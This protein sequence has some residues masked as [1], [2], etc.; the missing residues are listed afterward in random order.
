MPRSG[1]TLVE[2]ILASHPQVH[3]AG[4]LNNLERVVK[5][6]TDSAGRPVALS[7]VD[8]GRSTPILC[9]DSARRIWP[10][11]RLPEGK[12]ADRRQGAEELFACVG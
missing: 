1:S 7:G 9:G 10:A 6:V 12:D 3:A 11:C 5:T 2:Q 4:E 8:L